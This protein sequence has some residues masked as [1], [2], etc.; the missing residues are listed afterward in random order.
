MLH[1]NEGTTAGDKEDDG[2]TI[3]LSRNGWGL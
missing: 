2:Q 1:F 3:Q